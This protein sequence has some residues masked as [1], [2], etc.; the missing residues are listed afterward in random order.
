M[1]SES[2]QYIQGATWDPLGAFVVTFSCD[3]SAGS[4]LL[5][6]EGLAELLLS[7]H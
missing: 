2:K 6:A 1:L 4:V 5:K 7:F 3:R